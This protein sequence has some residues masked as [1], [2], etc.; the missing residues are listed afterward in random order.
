[1]MRG[2]LCCMAGLFLAGCGD[3]I[4]SFEPVVDGYK[5]P[6]YNQDLAQCRELSKQANAR[7]AEEAK[8]GAIVGAVIGAAIADDG[9]RA[10][11]AIAGAGVGALGATADASEQADARKER[12]LVSCMQRR[13]HN[14]L[15]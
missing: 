11:A 2:I 3:T 5:S 13:G 12:I 10:E 7:V 8:A 6:A 14:V 15:G 9:E 1:M 4:D